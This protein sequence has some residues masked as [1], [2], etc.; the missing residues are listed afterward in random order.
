[1]VSIAD[2]NA[3]GAEELVLLERCGAEGT[4]YA[5]V[6]DAWTGERLNILGF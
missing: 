6:K 2:I 5:V 1:M 4:L 3:N